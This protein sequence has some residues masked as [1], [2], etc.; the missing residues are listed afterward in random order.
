[1][2]LR[3]GNFCA[4]M[5]F[6]DK[7]SGLNYQSTATCFKFQD[8]LWSLGYVA[9]CRSLSSLCSDSLSTQW[10]HH[11]PVMECVL[12]YSELLRL[13]PTATGILFIHN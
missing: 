5:C 12:K 4:L 9:M 7:V 3:A 2:S 13:R 8:F 10:G 6:R 1:M 11:I